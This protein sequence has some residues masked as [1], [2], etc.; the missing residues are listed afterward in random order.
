MIKIF[1]HKKSNKFVSHHIIK[2]FCNNNTIQNK[3]KFFFITENTSISDLNYKEEIFEY[4]SYNYQK[5]NVDEL[6]QIL[7]KIKNLYILETEV[8][9]LKCFIRDFIEISHQIKDEELIV[10]LI[11]FFTSK[12]AQVE[13]YI[14]D[15]NALEINEIDKDFF[16]HVNNLFEFISSH[17]KY[18]KSNDNLIE[19]FYFLQKFDIEEKELCNDFIV[20]MINHFK[21]N[22]SLH[23]KSNNLNSTKI[24]R[25]IL[26]FYDAGKISNIE[27]IKFILNNYILK[28]FDPIKLNMIIHL[29]N[30]EITEDILSEIKL[31]YCALVSI[32]KN[33]DDESLKMIKNQLNIIKN[34]F[35]KILKEMEVDLEKLI[36]KSILEANEKNNKTD[37]LEKIKN[38]YI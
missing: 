35:D 9:D 6:K 38:K 23:I 17:V 7:G 4:F 24:L 5:L 19:I 36:T 28:I 33:K 16:N 31:I 18:I 13:E 14:H 37:I 20:N 21:L 29:N 30:L 10:E 2:K 26:S 1:F 27:S 15:S 25:I 12:F 34:S 32:L 8:R 22:E 11:S 3:Q